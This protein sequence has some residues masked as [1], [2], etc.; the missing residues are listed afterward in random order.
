MEPQTTPNTQSNLGKKKNK[1][2]GI[3]LPDF[4]LHHKATVKKSTV[5]DKYSYLYQWNRIE[6]PE[7]NPCPYGQLIYNK[8]GKNIKRKESL[9]NKWCWEDWT[10]PCKKLRSQHF[11][12]SYTKIFLCSTPSWPQPQHVEVPGSRKDWTHT[13][14]STWATA[15][16]PDP[17][18]AA[19]QGN[20]P[21]AKIKSKWVKDLMK[22]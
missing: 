11:L 20:S 21:C 7:I 4:R 16:T 10:A 8:G 14:A 6:S 2:G 5:Q 17:E 9:F 18:P 12:T 15:V 13:T 1:T 3:T 22:D 19:P